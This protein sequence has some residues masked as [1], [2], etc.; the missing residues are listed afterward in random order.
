MLTR[1]IRYLILSSIV[2]TSLSLSSPHYPIDLQPFLRYLPFIDT[3][4]MHFGAC[5][6]NQD[7]GVSLIFQKIN[8]TTSRFF[9]FLDLQAPKCSNRVFTLK[10]SMGNPERR[11]R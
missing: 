8:K 5:Q 4:T 3:V 6:L 10:V 2:G 11:Y 9:V 7:L 1:D